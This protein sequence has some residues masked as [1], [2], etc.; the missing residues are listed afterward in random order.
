MSLVERQA[1]EGPASRVGEASL[2]SVLGRLG[3]LSGGCDFRQ[4]SEGQIHS[5]TER[6]F[7]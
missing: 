3:R 6:V 5:V 4:N 7:I 1:G 2:D